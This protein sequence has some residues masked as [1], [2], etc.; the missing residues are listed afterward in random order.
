MNALCLIK[1]EHFERSVS[2]SP[3]YQSKIQ[4]I[5]M[6]IPLPC[7]LRILLFP[8]ALNYSAPNFKSMLHI[9]HF[10][11]CSIYGYYFANFYKFLI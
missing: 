10:I 9:I 8:L 3:F 5:Y 11:V 6:L 7:L 4:R 2:P 1:D